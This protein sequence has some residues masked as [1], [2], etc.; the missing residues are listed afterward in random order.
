L[1]ILVVHQYYLAPGEPGGSRFNEFAQLWK[2]SGHDVSV[3]AGTMNYATGQSNQSGRRWITHRDEDGIRVTRCHV[4][5]TYKQS[6]AGRMWAFFGFTLLASWEALRISRPDVIVATSPPLTAAIPGFIA[7]RVRLRPV[8]WVFEIRD[9]WPESA[10]TTGVLSERGLLTRVLYQLERFA[11]QHADRVNVLTPA[12]AEDLR[13]RGLVENEQLVFVPN[14]V[15]IDAFRPIPRDDHVRREFGWG[16]RFVALYAGAH[17][18]A[19]ALVQLLDAAE[20]L[21][22]RPDILIASVGDGPERGVLETEVRVRKLSNVQFMGPLPKTRMPAVIAAA[23]VGLAV[24]QDNPT[25]RTVYPNKVFD[26]MACGRATVLAIDGVAR[27]LVCDEAR[28]G[29]F[30]EPE[31]G[32]AIADAIT[33]LA[34]FPEEARLLGNNGRE[35][36]LANGAR[37]A[38][39]EKYLHV[40][41]SMSANRTKV[42]APVP[43][44]PI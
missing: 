31:N 40:L 35:W 34:D 30:A 21:R 19:N 11:C 4:S 6:Y 14:G 3:I 17:G 5:A 23:D 41:T 7:A 2:K 20:H 37:S 28:A 33:M 36:V 39:A 12:F 32:R 27:R 10:I 13:K 43:A 8:P 15:D 25:F 26:Y 38:L 44:R 42:T 16:Q 29:V 1:N 9:L 18:R 24:L 22:T